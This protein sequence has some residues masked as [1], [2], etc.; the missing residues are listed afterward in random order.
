MPIICSFFGITIRMFFTEHEPAH[1][2][3]EHQ[4]DDGTFGF[5]GKLIN[6]RMRSTAARK[7][8]RRWARL[9]RRELEENWARIRRG[10]PLERIPPLL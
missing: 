5:D 1:F 2:H 6:G 10:T 8:I 4:R 3:A 7:R 9:H